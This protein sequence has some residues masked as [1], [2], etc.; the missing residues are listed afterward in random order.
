[1]TGPATFLIEKYNQCHGPG[2]KFCSS[3]KSGGG[4]GD[5]PHYAEE[6][7]PELTE[8]LMVD[9]KTAMSF[10]LTKEDIEVVSDY[11]GSGY[12]VM[13]GS[14]RREAVNPVPPKVQDKVDKLDAVLA[15]TTLDQDTVVYRG[16]TSSSIAHS[17]SKLKGS[18]IEDPAF[19]STSKSLSV[20][21]QFAQ[22][23]SLQREQMPILMEIRLPKGT[24]ALDL[25]KKVPSPMSDREQEVL[26]PRRTRLKVLDSKYD[27]VGSKMGVRMVLT[28]E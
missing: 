14:L 25:A 8:A 23:S 10:G 26:M 6:G 24:H 21:N 11:Q 5:T 16:L 3:G 28:P 27:Q 12:A 7:S 18:V 2:G 22:S 13:N 1:M 19:I 17:A 9:A 15:K 20:A 4:S